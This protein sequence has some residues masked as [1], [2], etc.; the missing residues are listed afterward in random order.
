MVTLACAPVLLAQ[1]L[2]VRRAALRLPEAAGP[3]AGSL[4]PNTGP[5]LDTHP[6]T[7]LRLLII[8]DS[9][10]AGVGAPAQSQALAGAVTRALARHTPLDWQLIA[11]TGATT[12]STLAQL[13]ARELPRTDIAILVL[14]VNDVTRGGPRGT[15]LRRHA[16]LRAL[17]RARTGARRLYICE[18]PPLGA[19]PLLP[20]PLRWLLGRRA[21]RFDRSL[22]RALTHEPDTAIVP[23]PGTLDVADMAADGFH[24]G[25]VIYAAWGTQ[26][27]RQILSDGPLPDP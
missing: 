19:F 7:P 21:A 15:W 23:L 4:G 3:R 18:I 22:R 13:E 5:D 24:P 17:L 14:G 27:A 20:Q 16:A 9:S 10:A 2:R 11:R 8:G 6:R 1:A 26:M 12:A 25:P